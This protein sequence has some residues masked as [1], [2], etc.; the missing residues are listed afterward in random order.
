[1]LKFNSNHVGMESIC[2]YYWHFLGETADFV[3]DTRSVFP[4][5]DLPN[6]SL[7]YSNYTNN[8]YLSAA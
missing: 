7:N 2:E 8:D 5:P 4:C 6:S 1:M 3:I